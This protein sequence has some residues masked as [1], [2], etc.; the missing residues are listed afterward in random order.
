[1]H[2]HDAYTKIE[3]MLR[4]KLDIHSATNAESD[5]RVLSLMIDFFPPSSSTAGCSA[6][7]RSQ[8]DTARF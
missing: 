8:P 3:T 5:R 7:K 4:L 2:M 1:M 6:A